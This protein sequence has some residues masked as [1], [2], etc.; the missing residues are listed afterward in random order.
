MRLTSI[1]ILLLITQSA[2]AQF[3]LIEDKEGFVNV[4]RSGEYG[5]NIIDTLRNGDIVFSFEL[6]NDWYPIDYKEKGEN[7]TGFVHKTRLKFISDFAKIPHN[8]FSDNIVIFMN[9]SIKLTLTKTEFVPKNNKLDFV[10]A[11]SSMKEAT[12]LEK[13]NGKEV[14]G[15]YGAIP[16]TQ[17]GQVLLELP[18]KK[19]ILPSENL[20]APNLKYTSLNYD[21]KTNTIYVSA[22][23]SDGAGAYA[24]LW[25]I[26]NRKYKQRILT[27]PF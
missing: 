7:R 4:R 27:I 23:N 26:E 1:F 11:N 22:D 10:K 3:A 25:V 17:Y 5:D 24:V 2:I 9:D 18:N 21:A 12:I 20:F 14:W 19:I 13:V 15:T 6:Q 16:K 8:S